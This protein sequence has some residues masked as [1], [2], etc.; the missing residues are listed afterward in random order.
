MAWAVVMAH[1]STLSLRMYW[2]FSFV[3][4]AL[5][6]ATGFYWAFFPE[7]NAMGINISSTPYER[8]VVTSKT[9]AL[10]F[11]ASGLPII[12]VLFGFYFLRKLFY[13]Y[14]Q[15]KVFIL[16]NVHLYRKIGWTLLVLAITENIFDTLISIIM[17]WNH[18][19]GSMVAFGV[20]ST[21]VSYVLVGL[22]VVLISHVM[23]QAYLLEDEVQHTI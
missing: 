10:G 9:Q 1:I 16:D 7:M 22:T 4:V 8:M 18:P 20:C 2:V 21:Q 14:S 19:Q 13:H 23:Q 11:F 6:I 12:N 17:T 15:G 5:P 3:L